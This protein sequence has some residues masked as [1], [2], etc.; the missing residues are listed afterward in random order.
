MMNDT[1][2]PSPSADFMHS[3]IHSPNDSSS[4][5]QKVRRNQRILLLIL[6]L[7]VIAG[8]TLFMSLNTQD[9]TT[10]KKAAVH[11]SILAP[12]GAL[13]PRDAW[14][15][16]ADAQL[17]SIETDARD[18]AQKNTVLEKQ[19]QAML[20]RLKKLEEEGLGPLPPPPRDVAP[21]KMPALVDRPGVFTP[22]QT[23]PNRST[24]NAGSVTNGN[25]P[26]RADNQSANSIRSSPLTAP[27]PIEQNAP[28]S[29]GFDATKSAPANPPNP[30]NPANPL[31]PVNPLNPPPGE[32]AI[33]SIQL[34]PIH[35]SPET[36]RSAITP[37]SDSAQA[38]KSLPSASAS[39]NTF[40]GKTPPQNLPAR[41][42]PNHDTR[43]YLPSGSFTRALLLG[44]LDAPTGG[45]SQRNP[46]P[47]LLRL[48]DKAMLPNAFRSEI[49]DCFVV[50]AGYGDISSERAYIRTES[51]SCIS[52]QGQAIDIPIKGYIAGE[53]GKAGMR[54]RLVSKQG[55]VLANA[56]LAGVASGI[57][58]SFQQSA[59]TVSVSPLGSTSTIDT[60]KQLEAGLGTGVGKSLDRLSQ[61]YITL[62]EKIFPVIEIDAGRSVDIVLTSGVN[63]PHPLDQSVA[64][65]GSTFQRRDQQRETEGRG[66]Q[67]ESPLKRGRVVR[68]PVTTQTSLDPAKETGTDRSSGSAPSSASLNPFILPPSTQ[69]RNP[70][71]FNPIQDPLQPKDTVDHDTLSP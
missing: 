6:A 25:A 66:A 53:D 51:L 13:D 35:W 12:G 63:L 31:N 71:F 65:K 50:G 62:A 26:L 33:L 48:T 9:K 70:P 23:N 61:Y 8:A 54:G 3:G 10:N 32:R 28:P 46:Q 1:P 38:P 39:G 43:H 19:N 41:A 29:I 5:T 30:W 59:T 52:R 4:L 27:T 68:P 64:P 47:V 67:E 36:D 69:A 44:G 15:G 34:T 2:P 56:L 18:S 14:R 45:Q 11:S 20:S 24:A 17:K 21:L 22:S 58:H 57:G 16:Q 40:S 49:R 42:T 37:T 60:G 55:Q 7:G